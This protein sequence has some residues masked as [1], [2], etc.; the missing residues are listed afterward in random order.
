M[1]HTDEI[2]RDVFNALRR[3][4][5][6]KDEAVDAMAEMERSHLIFGKVYGATEFG[7]LSEQLFRERVTHSFRKQ[8]GRPVI[9]NA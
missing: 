1:F 8:T 3:T 5:L 4:G 9:V 6:N 2:R 7:E